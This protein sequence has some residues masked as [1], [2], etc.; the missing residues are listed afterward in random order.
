[1]STITIIEMAL[2]SLLL[3]Y[4]FS[5]RSMSRETVEGGLEN[6]MGATPKV[7][8]LSINSS[9]VFSK[10]MGDTVGEDDQAEEYVSLLSVRHEQRCIHLSRLSVRSPGEFL[11][12]TIIKR[13]FRI[14]VS[15]KNVFMKTEAQTIT[16]R[17]MSRCM[18][19]HERCCCFSRYIG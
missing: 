16:R 1:M 7:P 14:K 5:R 19:S 8:G 13:I 2:F 10:V 3:S 6:G 9:A 12:V 4:L 17:S 11:I 15:P 18:V